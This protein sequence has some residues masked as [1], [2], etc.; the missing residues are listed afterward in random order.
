MDSPPA[1]WGSKKAPVADSDLTTGGCGVQPGRHAFLCLRRHVHL[2]HLVLFSPFSM[3]TAPYLARVTVELTGDGCA[4][5]LIEIVLELGAVVPWEEHVHL[6][7]KGGQQG[8]KIRRR[9]RRSFRPCGL[10]AAG[11]PCCTVP[12]GCQRR[13]TCHRSR[14]PA[15]GT[16][17][18][19]T[20]RTW[21][22]CIA[23]EHRR[24]L[25]RS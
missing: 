12:R 25:A 14:G 13:R 1:T 18:T 11:S 9:I 19:R 2:F 20:C 6:A 24:V 17:G 4:A 16:P 22:N 23:A 10:L 7:T 21:V 15:R 5:P 8:K 3:H